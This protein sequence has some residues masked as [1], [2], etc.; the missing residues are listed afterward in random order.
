[1]RTRRRATAWYLYLMVFLT[2]IVAITVEKAV[3]KFFKVLQ[4]QATDFVH[5]N[6]NQ[7]RHGRK[8]PAE[9][10]D[11]LS[12]IEESEKH[13]WTRETA[14]MFYDRTRA[15]HLDYINRTDG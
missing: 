14:M 6:E 15:F 8:R 7:R 5:S 4:N 13:T 12:E 10:D 9:D 3:T 2:V 11:L 1:M